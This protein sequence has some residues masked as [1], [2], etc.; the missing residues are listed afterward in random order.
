MGKDGKKSEPAFE[1]ANSFKLGNIKLTDLVSMVIENDG[2]LD[3]V[4]D[5]RRGESAAI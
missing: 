5:V 3:L 1:S 2:F 4:N